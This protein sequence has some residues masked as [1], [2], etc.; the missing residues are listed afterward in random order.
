ML[1]QPSGPVHLSLTHDALTGD[2]AADYTPAPVS[3][4]FAGAMPLSLAAAEAALTLLARAQRI[5]ILAGA[6]VEHDSAAADLSAAAERW[7]IPVATTCGRRACSP[8]TATSPSVSLD[9]PA[10]GFGTRRASRHHGRS[11]NSP[12]GPF[13]WKLGAFWRLCFGRAMIMTRRKIAWSS[14]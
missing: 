11:A 8:K 13:L 4:F 1:A 7:S 6:G 5:S 3:N 2:C 14:R 10:Q 12:C 9:T